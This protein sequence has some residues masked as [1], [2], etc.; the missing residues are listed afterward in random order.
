MDNEGSMFMFSGI[1]IPLSVDMIKKEEHQ[2]KQRF[3]FVLPPQYKPAPSFSVGD[4]IMERYTVKGHFHGNMGDVYQCYDK[5]LRSDV[6][7][8]TLISNNRANN[9]YYDFFMEEVQ[10]RL[11]LDFH[12]NV[13]SLMLVEN[14][15]GYPYIV[16]EW[17][18]GDA[19][20]GNSLDCWIGSYP[21][22]MGE[23]L[24][25]MLQI[26]KGLR[27]CHDQLSKEGCPFVLGDLKP[28]NILV[29]NDHTFKLMDFSTHSF[30]KHGWASPEQLNGEALDERSDIYTLGLIA[31]SIFEQTDTKTQES[32]LGQKLKK[33]IAYCKEPDLQARMPS[34]KALQEALLECCKE[35]QIPVHKDKIKYRTF[36]DCLYRFYSEINM[37]WAISTTTTLMDASYARSLMSKKYI[38]LIEYMEYTRNE[39]REIYEA[40]AARRRGDFKKALEILSCATMPKGKTP[41]FFYIRGLVFYSMNELSAAVDD[42]VMSSKNELFYPA[43]NLMADLL[44]QDPALT[45]KAGRVAEIK[46]I[47]GK[48][49]QNLEKNATGYMVNQVYGKFLMLFGDYASASRAFQESLWYPNFAE[50]SNLYYFGVCEYRQKNIYVALT[51]FFTTIQV[52]TSDPNY[53]EDKQKAIVLLYCFYTLGEESKTAELAAAISE[54]YGDNFQYLLDSL[55]HDITQVNIYFQRVIEAE[56]QYSDDPVAL[57]DELQNLMFSV[58]QERPVSSDTLMSDLFV[59]IASR[60]TALL[61]NDQ[62]YSEA[63]KVCD[64]VLLFDHCHPGMLQNKGTCLFMKKEVD[65]ARRYYELAEYYD[66]DPQ[67]KQSYAGL[68]EKLVNCGG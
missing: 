17:V 6:A 48:M 34:Y 28:E 1:V 15:N 51:I 42:F 16:S 24:D 40:E 54:K 30:T 63:V 49:A 47:L 55:R 2:A 64:R 5:Y 35:F 45:N 66:Q 29:A 13:T 32:P 50:W 19:T 27:H 20:F 61:Y 7:L 37:G 60:I 43:L 33:L 41:K 4:E 21:F 9:M 26:C 57:R 65:E 68:F 25:L 10:Q 44:L 56:A 59:S 12:P 18:E 11:H 38:S 53:L 67:R 39:D 62:K 58:E 52:I 8:K 31:Y 3:S 23:I 46:I 36:L 14:I 22:T